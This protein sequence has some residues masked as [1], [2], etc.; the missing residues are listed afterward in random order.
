MDY[1]R[2]EKDLKSNDY[3]VAT[4]TSTKPLIVNDLICDPN[5]VSLINDKI[6]DKGNEHNHFNCKRC[7]APNQTDVCEYCGYVYEED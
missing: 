2:F 7:G 4:T 1:W 3:W 5:P 6:Y